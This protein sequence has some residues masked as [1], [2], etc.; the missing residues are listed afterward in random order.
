[1]TKI[2]YYFKDIDTPMYQWQHYHIFDELAKHNIEIDILNPL[3][4]SCPDEANEILIRH[5]KESRYDLF[6]TSLYE[7]DIYI[8]SLDEIRRVGTPS[9]LICFD[10]LIVP[11]RHKNIARHFDLVWLTSFETKYLFDKWGANSVF[12]P[13][14]ANP[15]IQLKRNNDINNNQVLFIGTPYGSRTKMVNTL[16]NN[17][18]PVALYSNI[19]QTKRS[20]KDSI[21]IKKYE[22]PI[23]T[24]FN[25]LSFPIG[26]KLAI[27]SVRNKLSKQRELMI[28]NPNLTIR[29]SVGFDEMMSLYANHSLSLSSIAA[30]HT[31]ILENP[32]PVIN[33]RSFEIPMAGGVL[34]CAHT[35]E[36]NEY[37]E[38]GKE[39][40]YYRSD[41]EMIDKSRFYLGDNHISTINMIKEN[42]KL[43]AQN[44]HTW[45]NRFSV[46]FNTLGI[47]VD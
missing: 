28:G 15:F 40:I 2:L 39:A 7:N 4:F 27:A 30:R 38:D 16:L 23:H 11:H 21:L 43:R 1:M 18:I 5:V 44:E 35:P 42:A 10:N 34:F 36:L 13:Y 45:F 26:R 22:S 19:S 8:S 33:L 17:N 29:P 31:G 20:G 37:F 14:A 41:E 3:D 12:L 24:I 32:V 25:M 6:M 9:L 47:T 46:I